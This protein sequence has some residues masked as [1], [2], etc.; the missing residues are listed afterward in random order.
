MTLDVDALPT[1]LT[2]AEK[3]A[4]TSGSGFK[5][6]MPV[7]RVG[8]PRI[9]VSDGPGESVRPIGREVPAPPGRQLVVPELPR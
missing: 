3:S 5:F 6:T 1:E 4:L 7:D 2:L 9:M 8:M